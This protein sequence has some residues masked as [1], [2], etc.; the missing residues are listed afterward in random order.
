MNSEKALKTGF[1]DAARKGI[2]AFNL[3]HGYG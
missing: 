3:I 2:A 1:L